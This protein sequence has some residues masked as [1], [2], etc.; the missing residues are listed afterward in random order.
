MKMNNARKETLKKMII[1]MEKHSTW[2]VRP[3]RKTR[4][5]AIKKYLNDEFNKLSTCFDVEAC[6]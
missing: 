1:R 2:C 5:L 6:F 4:I 3:S